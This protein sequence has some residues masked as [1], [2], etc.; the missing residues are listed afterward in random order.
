MSEILIEEAA[1]H[2]A[3]AEVWSV[4]QEI[5]ELVARV[6]TIER[7][8]DVATGATAVTVWADGTEGY[9]VHNL[10]DSADP[11]LVA[12]A[13]AVGRALARP[14]APPARP[15]APAPA[16]DVLPPRLDAEVTERIR[17]FSEA[18]GDLEVELRVRADRTR[19]RLHRAGAAPAQYDTGVVQVQARLTARGDGIG[20]IGHQS[21][22]RSVGDLLDTVEKVELPE[23][24]D[25]AGI[26]ASS[27][28]SRLAYDDLLVDGRVLVRLLSLVVPAFLL[29]SVL[30][31]RSPL[32]ERT[33]ERVAAPGITLIDD[34]TAEASPLP[35]P[36]DGE[37]TPCG[38]TVLV[39]DG[40]LRGFLSARRTA[41]EAGTTSTGSGQRG[42][43]GE[44]STV[45]PGYLLLRH[46]T[47]L[48]TEVREGRTVLHV[49]Q[50][51]GAH[52]SNPITGD[53]SI[54]ANA[55]VVTPEGTRRN[56]GNITLA[57]NVF[58]LL[59]NIDGHDGRIRV[60]RGNNSFV[61]G[62]G[63]WTTSLTTGR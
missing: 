13:L 35:A 21:Y 9:A 29:D 23:L 15:A 52:T 14:A 17:Q 47:D 4:R 49:V 37:G 3:D 36:W 59:E 18:D 53:F 57:G 19:V 26:L 63:V 25:L 43:N 58:D 34:P 33:G 62:P 1:R 38:P 8:S 27:P 48:G 11:A 5:D 10:P 12:D 44:M 6:G 32:A 39:E 28:V 16:P 56:A 20:Y 22:G 51:N 42:P 54:G 61:A 60:N 50:A 2:G 41:A 55:V 46:T 31:G 7:R 45:Q 40:V 30:E 24:R